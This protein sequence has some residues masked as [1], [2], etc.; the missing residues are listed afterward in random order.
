MICRTCRSYENVETILE[1]RYLAVLDNSQT[2]NKYGNY[3]DF[4]TIAGRKAYH[5]SVKSDRKLP[6]TNNFRPRSRPL[7]G[8]V[9]YQK[10][11]RKKFAKTKLEKV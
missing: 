10:F 11:D 4:S 6:K 1:T 9:H 7:I 3:Q 8:F 2:A 5:I